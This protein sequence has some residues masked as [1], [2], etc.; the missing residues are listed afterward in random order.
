[1]PC[2]RRCLHSSHRWGPNGM[3][4]LPAARP[5]CEPGSLPGHA[6]SSPEDA[7]ASEA[8]VGSIR[9]CRAIA[10]SQLGSTRLVVPSPRHTSLRSSDRQRRAAIATAP[11]LGPSTATSLLRWFWEFACRQP[12]CRRVTGRRDQQRERS[13]SSA[14]HVVMSFVGVSI[15]ARIFAVRAS[16]ASPAAANY[17]D[18]G[19]DAVLR[20]G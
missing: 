7:P 3:R 19:P 4:R 18:P 12:T 16:R 20:C 2:R 13:T 8:I 14:W 15:I 9:S 1:M 10:L 17:D 6:G 11:H 5:R